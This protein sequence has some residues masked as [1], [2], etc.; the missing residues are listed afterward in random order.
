MSSALYSA[1]VRLIVVMDPIVSIKPVKD[2]TLAML[3]SAQK[4]GWELW[5]AEQQDLYLRDGIAH[6]QLRPL[7]VHDD[8]KHWFELGPMQVAPLAQYD[9]I[10]MRKDP[11]F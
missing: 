2:T 4:R 8:L 9:V 1:P 6:G 5:Y 7:R 10:L 11:P 3:L